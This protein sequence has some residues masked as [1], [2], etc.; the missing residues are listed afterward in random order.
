MCK[1]GENQTPYVLKSAEPFICLFFFNGEFIKFNS[2][3]QRLPVST[4]ENVFTRKAFHGNT[5]DLQSSVVRA[6]A[7]LRAGVSHPYLP[8]KQGQ[9]GTTPL[10][11]QAATKPWHSTACGVRN[12]W[13]CR[14][15]CEEHIGPNSLQIWVSAFRRQRRK[16]YIS[17]LSSFPHYSSVTASTYAIF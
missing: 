2:F 9:T 4:D 17:A 5:P 8:G 14:E 7:A 10:A 12:E 6:P 1:T 15:K 3:P 13:D 11:H 16:Q